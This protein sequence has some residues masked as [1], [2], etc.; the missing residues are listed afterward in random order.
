MRLPV[1][2]LEFLNFTQS[3]SINKII[4]SSQSDSSANH[5]SCLGVI[6]LLSKHVCQIVEGCTILGVRLNCLAK[7][8]FRSGEI[9]YSVAA[10][11]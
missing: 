11:T 2:I 6:P 7:S 4:W 5:L 8:P 9:P 10:I 3:L 1:H